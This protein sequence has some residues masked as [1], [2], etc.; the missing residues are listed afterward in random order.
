MF[1]FPNL[2]QYAGFFIVAYWAL[3]VILHVALAVSV[4][5]HGSDRRDQGTSVLLAPLA[6]WTLA[7]LL[8]GLLP[9]FAYWAVNASTLRPVTPSE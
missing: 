4:Y 5:Q 9:A 8:G 7:A 2:G 1:P 3:V 6:I